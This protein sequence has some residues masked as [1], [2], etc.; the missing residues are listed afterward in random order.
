MKIHKLLRCSL[1]LALLAPC[2]PV[3][4]AAPQ[5]A[6]GSALLFDA[7]TGEVLFKKNHLEQRPV[8]STQKLL[9]ALLIA[10]EGDLDHM[11]T[12][13]REDTL[14]QPTKL[15]L[16]E[17][18]RYSRLQLLE[19]MLVRSPN[20]AASALARDNAGSEVAFAEKMNQR[21]RE[22][23]GSNSNFVTAS[24]LPA[25]NQYSTARDMAIVARAVYMNPVLRTIMMRPTV[26]FRFADG[27]TT[28]LRNTNQV[29]RSYPFC[30]GMKTGFTRAS[31]HCLISSGSWQG[32]HVIAVV[33][34]SN[35]PAVWNESAAL[36]AYG[37][38]LNQTTL[39]A[40]RGMGTPN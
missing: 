30:N 9:T 22:L 34:G 40:L 14:A 37:L 23:G 1:F 25:P 35:R 24:G 7:R 13:Q 21:M 38:G 32:R 10:E 18:D 5:I 16:K 39:A 4:A 20:D 17:G 11:V 27:R 33:L 15:Y 31:G 2:A 26:Q 36:L 8:A 3:A 29:M 19:A 28:T 12:I 6:A